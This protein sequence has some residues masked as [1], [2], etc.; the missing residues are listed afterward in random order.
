MFTYH[1]NLELHYQ[2]RL[3]SVVIH[4]NLFVNKKSKGNCICVQIQGGPSF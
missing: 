1:N 3:F 2:A 4:L